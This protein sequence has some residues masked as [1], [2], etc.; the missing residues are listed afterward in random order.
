MDEK[1]YDLIEK[2]YTDLKSDISNVSSQ[3]T[4]MENDIR[5]VGNQ[6]T[7]M[8]NGLQPKVETALEG[9]KVVYEKLN[10]LEDKLDNI[11][12]KVEKQDVEIRVIKGVK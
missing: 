8:E 9:Y 12:S 11:S 6:V 1:I 10:V 4:K 5:N 3:V 2:M 7:K